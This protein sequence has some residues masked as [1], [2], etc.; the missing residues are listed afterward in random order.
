[1]PYQARSYPLVP[2]PQ[3]PDPMQGLSNLM[4]L[5]SQFEQSKRQTETIASEKAVKDAL[6]QSQGNLDTAIEMLGKQGRWNEA[7]VLRS[8]AAEIREAQQNELAAS[9]K[10]AREGFE[11][12]TRLLQGVEAAKTPEEKSALFATVRPQLLQALPGFAQYIP[13]RFEDDPEFVTRAIPMGLSYADAARR[14]DEAVTKLN[15]ATKDKRD[16]FSH[17]KSIVEALGTWLADADDGQDVVEAVTQAENLYGASP[18]VRAMLEDFT[19]P[20]PLSQAQRSALRTR[21]VGEDNKPTSITQAILRAR[22]SGDEKEVKALLGLQR[23]I[24][25]AGQAPAVGANPDVVSAVLKHPAIWN[26]INP[27]LRGGLIGPLSRSGFDFT[28][29]ASSLTDAQ[30]G[31]VERWK[32]DAL[33]KLRERLNSGG[34]EAIDKATYDTEVA[35]VEESYRAQMGTP[36]PAPTPGAASRVQQLKDSVLPRH[37]RSGAAAAAPAAPQKPAVTPPAG[38]PAVN[39][40]V[41][42]QGKRYKVVG[43]TSD[44]A[45]LEPIQ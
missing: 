7:T 45:Q 35:R 3:G 25:T 34:A 36:P 24:S 14:R 21:L 32:A 10:R 43:Y 28:K 37:L 22:E 30:K 39:T 20:G 6:G 13:N 31:V 23:Q 27:E 4:S 5:A 29:A 18:G 8:R 33:T 19:T 26:D 15:A 38:A 12:S 44:G 42:Y 40:T 16:Q 41:E 17:D 9:L 2:I 1:M 11:T